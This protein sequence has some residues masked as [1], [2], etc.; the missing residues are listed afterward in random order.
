MPTIVSSPAHLPALEG[1][2]LGVSGWMRI[3]QAE[4]D[5][6]AELTG[7]RQWIHVDP[8]RARDGPYGGT[9]AHGYYTLALANRFLPEI[10][11]VQGFTAGVNYGCERVRFPA[12]A[13]VGARIRGAAKLLV[14][15]AS[16][17]GVVKSTVRITVEIEGEARPACVVD[18]ISL[19][20]LPGESA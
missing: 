5:A 2:D 10:L 15:D 16:Q 1:R 7:D 20:Y 14:A 13:R 8:E 19:Y 6:F 12:P 3:T 9:V 17:A 11:E 4:V 18:T